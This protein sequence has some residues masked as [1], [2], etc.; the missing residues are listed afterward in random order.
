MF[1]RRLGGFLGVEHMKRL[2]C[3]HV[4]P[5]HIAMLSHHDDETC[6]ITSVGFER[7]QPA[8]ISAFSNMSDSLPQSWMNPESRQ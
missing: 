6:K 1:T 2:L 3:I 7:S 8:T 4:L 5:C